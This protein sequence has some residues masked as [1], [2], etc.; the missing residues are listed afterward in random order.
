MTDPLRTIPPIVALMGF[1]V[2]IVGGIAAANPAVSVIGNALVAMFVCL[3]IGEV[4]R[5]VV[6]TIAKEHH[7]AYGRQKPI[8][9]LMSFM[10]SEDGNVGEVPNNKIKKS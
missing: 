8:P 3:I 4:I 2:S 5:W 7:A 1:A 10:S 6:Q 9:P